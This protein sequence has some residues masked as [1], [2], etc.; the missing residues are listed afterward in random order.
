MI[1]NLRADQRMARVSWQFVCFPLPKVK[2]AQQG[3]PDK[4]QQARENSRADRNLP[5][6]KMHKVQQ[7][8]IER[9]KYTQHMQ[10]SD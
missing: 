10:K 9:T 4:I 2:Q 5:A 8:Q 6:Q 1:T 3:T 7:D